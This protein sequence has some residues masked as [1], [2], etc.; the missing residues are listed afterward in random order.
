MHS[1]RSVSVMRDIAD[2]ARSQPAHVSPKTHGISPTVTLVATII[3]VS[4]IV[5]M[6]IL[7]SR[8]ERRHS[9]MLDTPPSGVSPQPK[10]AAR[11][12]PHWRALCLLGSGLF[13][14]PMLTFA[15]AI[16]AVG[17]GAGV[18]RGVVTCG[19]ALT[20]L[21]AACFLVLTM[22]ITIVVVRARGTRPRTHQ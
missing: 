9:R 13:A 21:D 15:T 3:G 1:F 17:S 7:A 14:L 16:F 10:Q 6:P 5:G 22:L 20:V 11:V 8:W 19:V 18:V 12:N 2:I 4:V